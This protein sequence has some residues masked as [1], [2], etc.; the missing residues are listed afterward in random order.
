MADGITSALARAREAAGGKDVQISGGADTV[1]QFNAAGLLDEL[2]LHIA[3][4]ILGA[5]VRLCAG[6]GGRLLAGLISRTP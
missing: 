4:V 1:R 5:G 6:P 3:P 2:Q